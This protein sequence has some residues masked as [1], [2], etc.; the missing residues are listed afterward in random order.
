LSNLSHEKFNREQELS[1]AVEASKRLTIL[2][3][4]A[5]SQHPILESEIRKLE[6][7][8]DLLQER[9]A[10]LR[11]GSSSVD[12]EIS[13]ADRVLNELESEVSEVINHIATHKERILSHATA[14]ESCRE[15]ISVLEIELSGLES[16]MGSLPG[17]LMHLKDQ[18][19]SLDSQ[20]VELEYHIE[21]EKKKLENGGD[22]IMTESEKS[23][24]MERIK[25]LESQVGSATNL[26]NKLQTQIGNQKT[27]IRLM[28]KECQLLRDELQSITQKVL[29]TETVVTSLERE[30]ECAQKS[31]VDLLVFRDKL[32]ADLRDKKK[33][34]ADMI[35]RI[36]TTQTELSELQKTVTEK[37]REHSEKL[38]EL[39]LVNKG[40][41]QERHVLR[42]Q[43]WEIQH[44]GE[45]LAAKLESR[46][47]KEERSQ[48]PE[49]D[50]TAYMEEIERLKIAIDK[51]QSDL[52]QINDAFGYSGTGQEKE[53]AKLCREKEQLEAQVL[54]L[55]SNNSLATSSEHIEQSIVEW[56]QLVKEIIMKRCPLVYDEFVSLG[57]NLT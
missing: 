5:E 56:N 18:S 4:S 3:E 2:R 19:T 10:L 29:E 35:S 14:I 21:L 7:K 12:Q 13:D 46:K 24:L 55:P 31:L 53:L 15:E 52:D 20:L 42:K 23:N 39:K 32:T 36:Y 25:S 54:L 37:N 48:V 27:E 8:R 30:D 51:A 22:K 9:I 41:V 49:E 43:L 38:E 44:A 26:R 50:L 11:Q 1:R 16:Q 17:Q 57:I 47:E 6:K 45:L 33:E 40:L 28:G 34:L